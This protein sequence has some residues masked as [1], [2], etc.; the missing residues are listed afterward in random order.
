M[1]TTLLINVNEVKIDFCHAEDEPH[2]QFTSAMITV[3]TR[4][5]D[6]VPFDGISTT[7]CT[8]KRNTHTLVK[9][10]LPVILT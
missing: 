3:L 2:N 10:F 6:R 9:F 5:S 8:E 7:F 1:I 4:A